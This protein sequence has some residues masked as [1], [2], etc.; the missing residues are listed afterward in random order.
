MQFVPDYQTSLN[1]P[2]MGADILDLAVANALIRIHYDKIRSLEPKVQDQTYA[3][4]SI[5]FHYKDFESRKRF[6]GGMKV[7]LRLYFY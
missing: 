7:P 4:N 2:V 6:S 5:L 1:V 3:K